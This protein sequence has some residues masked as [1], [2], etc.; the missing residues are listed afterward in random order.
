MWSVQQ[1]IDGL[2]QL[3]GGKARFTEKLDSMFTYTPASDE[4]LPIF[5]TGMIGQYAH[6]NEPGHH[7][8]Y[9]FNKVGQPWKTQQYA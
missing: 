7:V 3:V 8:I 4:E 1:D 5:S 6:G 9:L 2:I